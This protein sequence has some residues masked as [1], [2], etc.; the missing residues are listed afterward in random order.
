METHAHILNGKSIL[1]K[2]KTSLLGN[3][4][5]LR[6]FIVVQDVARFAVSALTDPGLRNRS[7]E[8]GGS[9]N[10]SDNQVAE[11]YGKLAGIVPEVRHLPP[12]VARVMSIVLSPFHPGISRIMYSNSLPDEAFSEVFDPTALLVEFSM[13]LTTIEEFIRERVAEMK[14]RPADGRAENSIDHQG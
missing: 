8:L 2:S 4:T 12:S 14:P 9:D 1:E 7:L 6:N 10:A 13:H 3:G 5:K 11:L